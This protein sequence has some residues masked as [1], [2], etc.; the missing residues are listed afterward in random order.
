M[1]EDPSLWGQP[2]DVNL[3]WKGIQ[4]TGLG[5][6]H[7]KGGSFNVCLGANSIPP[8]VARIEWIRSECDQPDERELKITLRHADD[9]DLRY[10]LELYLVES[11][12]TA[13]RD[14][15]IAFFDQSI[16][17]EEWKSRS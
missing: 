11:N 1:I 15:L 17:V 6:S 10:G 13:I 8:A 4:A 5:D 9:T 7:L 3:G 14:M 16:S 2:I 12:A